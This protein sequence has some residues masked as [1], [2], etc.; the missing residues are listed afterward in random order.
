MKR[1]LITALCITALT[2]SLMAL[3]AQAARS[4]PDLPED[5]WAYDSFVQANELGFV[6]GNPDG[7]VAPNGTLTWAQYLT[8]LSLAFCGDDYLSYSRP[9][10]AHW[11][12]PYY[13]TL[14]EAGGIKAFMP[15]LYDEPI[16]RQDAAVLAAALIDGGDVQSAPV[17]AA[18]DFSQIPEDYQSGVA[19]AYEL[20]L[21]SGYPDGTF[22]GTEGLT[23]AEGVVIV[24]NA[25]SQWEP[26]EPEPDY[27]NPLLWLGENS[28]KHLRLFG[29]ESKR[30]F[31]N[32]EEAEANMVTVTVPVWKL[33][34]GVK[35]SGQ[36]TF[37]IHQAIADEVVQMF[38]EI[39]NDPEQFPINSV[40]GYSWRGDTA[41]GEH[42]CGTAIDINPDANY[43]VREGKAMV[44]THWT[45][46]TDPLSISENGSVVRIFAAHGWA[47]GG[48]AWAWD[49]DPT[50]GYHD[51]MHFSYMGK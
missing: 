47:W 2:A 13:A 22:G 24:I 26:E 21:V 42:N 48:D 23:R 18:A 11:A 4:W 15:V 5:H 8:M 12:Y 14:D 17:P 31:A 41:T 43:Q 25:L 16:S 27:D 32:K 36:A 7:T 35:S 10:K 6:N 37:R 1:N 3:P 34:N 44:G 46:D 33:K 29:D 9:E 19:R 39:Y 38:T 30:R 28:A 51:Y 40:G 20:G 50:Y 45:P 49:A